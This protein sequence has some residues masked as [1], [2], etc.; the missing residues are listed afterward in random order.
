MDQREL[1]PP[2]PTENEVKCD[3]NNNQEEEGEQFDFDSGDEVPEA[4]RQAPSTP[5]VRGAEAGE[6]PE[7][8]RAV[9]PAG[10]RNGATM[11]EPAKP[12][13]TKVNPYSV[14]DI[15]PFQ[16]DQPPSPDPNVEE[17]V[18]GLH[19]PSGYSVP[20][21]CG[22]AVPSNLP[23]LVPP[24]YSS[25][26]II[27]AESVEEEAETPEIMG[28]CPLSSLSSEDPPPSGDL[29]SQEGSALARWAADPANTAWMENPEEAIYDDVPRENSDSE[30][31]LILSGT[32]LRKCGL[33]FR[34]GAE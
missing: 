26:V 34:V 6:T 18:V 8:G 4:D 22:Y 23:L 13:T 17:D 30:P 29:G 9:S 10:G 25:P 3:N 12:I 28:D 15:T 5:G 11:A 24:A 32:E 1:P 33:V 16:E 19:V 14:I 21:P 27:R 31:G 2:V 7:A 20:V